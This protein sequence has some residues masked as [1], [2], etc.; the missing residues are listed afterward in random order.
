MTWALKVLLC[1]FS[2]LLSMKTNRNSSARLHTAVRVQALLVLQGTSS[3]IACTL[4]S[5][6]EPAS[7][8]YPY[9][10][11]PGRQLAVSV[12]HQP[13]SRGAHLKLNSNGNRF[14]PICSYFERS[15]LSTGNAPV[16]TKKHHGRA[17]TGHRSLVCTGH[18][19]VTYSDLLLSSC[20]RE[21]GVL[22]L[23]LSVPFAR[24][25]SR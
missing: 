12:K 3:H 1:I 9:R 14:F 7:H 8:S 24:R 16:N 13:E 10:S 18:N 4:E 22:F 23:R 25:Y 20:F 19:A 6:R 2:I 11:G 21:S 17:L 5:A 15:G